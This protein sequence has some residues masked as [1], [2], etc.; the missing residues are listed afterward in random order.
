M[1]KLSK[2][3]TAALLTAAFSAQSVSAANMYLTM[4]GTTDPDAVGV[5]LL[6]LNKGVALDNV[7]PADIKYL[8]QGDV[9]ADGSFSLRLPFLSQ[10]E[11]DFYSNSDYNLAN[12]ENPTKTVYVSDAGLAENTGESASSPI[13]LAKAYQNIDDTK[14]IIL[15]GNTTYTEAPAHI[16][17]LTIK[18]ENASTVLT[19]ASD[20]SLKGDT[21]FSNLTINGAKTVYANGYALTVDETVTSTDKLTV[22]GGANGKAVS[23]DTNVT[24]LGGLY[25][26]IYGGG[27]SGVVNGST[28]VTVGGNV[29]PGNTNND[30]GY[31]M[32]YGGGANAAVKGKT[33]V[34][35][36]D[37]AVVKYVFGAGTGANGTAVDTNINITGGK[38]MNVCGGSKETATVLTNCD[39]H[40]TMTGGLA[41]SLFGGSQYSNLTGNTYVN[42]L[43]GE[44]SRRVY[45]GCYNAVD[46]G[47]SGLSV[48]ATW[49][50]SY[51]VIGTTTLTLA[52]GVK[53]NTK[54]DLSSDN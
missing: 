37:N 44:V 45:T 49:A 2:I 29:N 17:N 5:T 19:L 27:N 54:T 16:K 10:E 18:A 46:F 36:A 11:Y 8:N 24:L 53:L 28:N 25:N 7:T 33:N 4:N 6:V 42:I 50:S 23:G 20:V 3:L 47:L 43:G 40:I 15:A 22:F 39:T 38:V 35:L 51:H 26:N 12:P 31:C 48:Q 32:V 1:K 34:T 21:T 13:T 30:Q 52:P 14:E 9:N 41:E